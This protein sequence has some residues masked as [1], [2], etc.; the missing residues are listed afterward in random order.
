MTK[1]IKTF[2]CA[3]IVVCISN[4]SIY[5]NSFSHSIIIGIGRSFYDGPESATFL[6]GST[7]TWEALVDLDSHLRPIP[8][9]AS[10]WIHNSDYTEW[11]FTL[12]KNVRF[13]NGDILTARHVIANIN[14]LKSNPKYDPLNRYGIVEKIYAPDDLNVV[15]L[16]NRPCPN[17]PQMISYYGSPILNP[18]GWGPD[19]KIK[20]FIATGPYKLVEI[21]RT[22]EEAL[23][24]ERNDQYWGK[25]PPYERII[26]RS[27]PDSHAR[28]TAL[29]AGTI[30][31]ILDIGGVLPHQKAIL[32]RDSAIAVKTLEVATTHYLLINNQAP[33]FNNEKFRRWF[34]SVIDRDVIVETIMEGQGKVALDPYSDLNCEW[35]FSSVFFEP[36]SFPDK[37][38]LQSAQRS[39]L[40]LLHGGTI[41]R[42]PYRE[43]SEYIASILRSRGFKTEIFVAEQALYF[44]LLKDKNYHLTM[45]PFT[46]MTGDPYMFYSTFLH[47]K[48]SRNTG[49]KDS[50]VDLLIDR[51]NSARS[52]EKRFIYRNLQKIIATHAVIIPLFHDEPI[53]AYK[54]VIG[55]I[56]MDVLF[57]PVY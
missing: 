39:I 33:P 45:M 31:A 37:N 27:I 10:S 24:L 12:R 38:S 57:R 23:V 46:L 41:S 2:L 18:L 40:I 14:R 55:S 51:A 32:S 54:K 6:H 8:W 1:V 34:A 44:A 42:W 17:F 19:G 5:A 15:F 43:I 47:S 13:H 28:L 20:Q 4:F 29:L 50:Y 9:L 16:L 52:T 7:R 49:W 53:Y 3:V 22:W 25:L 35:A 21:R 56:G 48:G 11:K 30:D 36:A 26:F